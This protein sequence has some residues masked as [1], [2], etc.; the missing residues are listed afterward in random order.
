MQHVCS[1]SPELV[2]AGFHALADPLRT[3]V[4][5][6]LRYRELCVGELCESLDINQSKLSF[7]LKVLKDAEL[8]NTRHEGRWIYYSL[9]LAQFVVLEQ[10]LAEYRRN[11]E[12]M[13]PRQY[14]SPTP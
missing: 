7:H 10:Y 1:A 5:E 6:L 14:L 13:P 12:I 9:N 3:D 8:V 2:F 4:L 11:S